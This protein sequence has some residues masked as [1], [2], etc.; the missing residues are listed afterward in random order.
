I[1]TRFQPGHV[2]N[3]RKPRGKAKLSG[4]FVADLT[5]EWRN[6]G[7]QALADLDGKSLVNACIAILPK[8]VLVT[9]D[10]SDKVA[11][12]INAQP[13]STLEWQAEHGLLVDDSQD[14]PLDSGECTVRPS[15]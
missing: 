12:V 9:M 5:H 13:L 4:Q 8:D 15:K 10:A 1:A 11:W 7:M 6:R 14:A 2:T 3:N